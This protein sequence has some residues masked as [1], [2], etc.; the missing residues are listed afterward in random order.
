M[1]YS[2]LGR[3]GLMV[4]R[5]GLGTMTYGSYNTAEEGF[6]QMDYALERGVNLFD[7]AEAYPVPPSPKTQGRT[8]TIIGD[9]CKARG[10]RDKIVIATKI[11]G[12]S[13]MDWFRK[14]GAPT[15]ITRA[16]IDEAVE[17]SLRRL[18]TDVIDL[19]Q[20][21]WP[22]RDITVWGT[23]VDVPFPRDFIDF[24]ETLEHLGR[25]V[26]KGTIRHLG[27]SNETPWGVMK[28]LAASEAR[29][30]P[31]IASIQNPYS[32]VNRT[33]EIGLSEVGTQEQVSLLAYSP[34]GQG[35]LSGKYQGGALPEGSRKAQ[36]NRLQRYEKVNA[37]TSIQSYVDLAR[38]HGLEP[39]ALALKFVDSRRFVTSTLIGA[40]TMDQLRADIAAFD[41]DW[42]PELDAA[43]DRLHN[44]HPNP[45]P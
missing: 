26:A 17:G 10:T 9:W 12:R 31:R 45:C 19:Y 8:E 40:T 13:D 16:Q 44:L 29:G 24:G 3:T 5:V 14:A 11:V 27:V 22:D 37:D 30:L 43:A 1:R 21:H 41:L 2:E 39:S 33:Y 18:K 32:L 4:S 15:R 20:I 34:L 35:Y 42:T 23:L 38:D 28:F 25:H 36:H 7:C 6:A